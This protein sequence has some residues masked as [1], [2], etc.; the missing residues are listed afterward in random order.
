MGS[1]MFVL[2]GLVGATCSVLPPRTVEVHPGL[3]VRPVQAYDGT[4]RSLR[5]LGSPLNAQPLGGFLTP[6]ADV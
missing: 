3:S 5:S 6:K 2:A 1:L 4:G